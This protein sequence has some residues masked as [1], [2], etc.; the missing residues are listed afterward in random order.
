MELWRHVPVPI[1]ST[2]SP[3][4]APQTPD[5]TDTYGRN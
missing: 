5:L 1:L 2:N 3:N 4:A